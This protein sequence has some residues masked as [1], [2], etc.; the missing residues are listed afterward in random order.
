MLLSKQVQPPNSKF[1]RYKTTK[2]FLVK[3]VVVGDLHDNTFND[4]DRELVK[5]NKAQN[6][7]F[8]IADGDIL[9]DDSKNSD[10]AMSFIKRLVKIAPVYYA[11]EIMSLNIWKIKI[12]KIY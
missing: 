4:N 8:I 5:T 7:D 1:L 11:Q 6:P 2:K 3:F 10:I 12:L 9:N